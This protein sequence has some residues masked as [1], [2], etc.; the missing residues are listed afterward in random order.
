MPSDPPRNP[1]GTLL[2]EQTIL[3]TEDDIR[4]F[5]TLVGDLNPIH[6]DQAIARAN[7]FDGVIA[8]GTQSTSLLM[9]AT[10]TYFSQ[11]GPTLGVAFEFQF[12]LP[13]RPNTAY[14]LWWRV[15]AETPHRRGTMVELTGGLSQ[16]DGV[17]ALAG[18][19]KL[20]KI[21]G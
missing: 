21:H 4:A 14:T 6:H 11:F 2:I 3:L 13:V 10:A 1:P 20:L 7:G 19:G 12:L 15:V 16:P 18:H 17:L 8:S 5:A 9:A